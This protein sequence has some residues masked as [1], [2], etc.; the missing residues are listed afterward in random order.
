[1]FKTILVPL[2]LNQ[3]LVIDT[4]FEAVKSAA[5]PEPAR[6]VLMTVIPDIDVGGFPYV[7]TEYLEQLGTVMM[8]LI[9]VTGT[10]ILEAET[11]DHD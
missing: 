2:D 9:A 11:P 7:K 1:M 5:A 10:V 4:V 3:E 6:I 8:I